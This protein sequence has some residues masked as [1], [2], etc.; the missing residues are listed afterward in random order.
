MGTRRRLL[1]LAFDE[2]A[3]IR[4][5]LCDCVDV[6][7]TEVLARLV[8]NLFV[9]SLCRNL[10][11]RF[12]HGFSQAGYRRLLFLQIRHNRQLSPDLDGGR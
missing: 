2:L 4:Y 12:G 7:I 1:R 5:S 3:T 8:V 9:F 11:A 6:L 10:D